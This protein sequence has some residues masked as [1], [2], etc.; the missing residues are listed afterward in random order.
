MLLI[1]T[2]NRVAGMPGVLT[3]TLLC[4]F[5]LL[6]CTDHPAD[7]ATYYLSPTGSDT[8]GDGSSV[9]PWKTLY[10]A[11]QAVP[12]R[13]GHII[14]LKEGIYLLDKTVNSFGTRAAVWINPGI[15]LEGE[16][17][18]TDRDKTVILTHQDSSFP[19]NGINISTGNFETSPGGM[20]NLTIDGD[21]FAGY[22]GVNTQKISNFTVDNVSFKNLSGSALG[23]NVTG[24]GSHVVGQDIS[25]NEVKNSY[26]SK[27]KGYCVGGDGWMNSSIHDCYMDNSDIANPSLSNPSPWGDCVNVFFVGSTRIYNN[28]MYAPSYTSPFT[29]WQQQQTQDTIC[30]FYSS[31]GNEIDHNELGQWVTLVGSTTLNGYDRII[32]VHDN[33][34]FFPYDVAGS[35]IELMCSDSDV[36]NN[37]IDNCEIG[38]LTDP[39]AV[40]AGNTADD[41][42]NVRVFNNVFRRTFSGALYESY[43]IAFRNSTNTTA[44]NW[45]I[46]NNVFDGFDRGF[47]MDGGGFVANLNV[48]NNVFLNTGRIINWGYPTVLITSANFTNNIWHY[49][50]DF[51]IN[52]APPAETNVVFANNLPGEATSLAA[53]S[54]AG[55]NLS[56]TLPTAFYAP[57][58]ETALPVN[59]GTANI[60]PGITLSGFSGSAPDIGVYEWTGDGDGNTAQTIAAA[61]A[62]PNPVTTGTTTALTAL[63]TNNGS[64][65]S[66]ARTFGDADR[67]SFSPDGVNG[68]KR[69]RGKE[70]HDSLYQSGNSRAS[71]YIEIQ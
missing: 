12:G 23:M 31:G 26:F 5:A 52:P 40:S 48:K 70:C 1:S 49:T 68:A 18:S 50:Q 67:A 9:N 19:G 45:S 56:G 2:K 38:I 51:D 15:T 63:G 53:A 71:D 29:S 35:A 57:S 44:R 22:G 64:A 61:S 24:N 47:Q 11:G 33:H 20:R 60:A 43:G 27:T 28:T 41:V 7:A 36:Y 66:L 34:V 25:G 37:Y 46:Y 8:S 30:L 21:D 13:Q 3:L 55:L 69:E 17:T 42:T 6:V 39:G 62:S 58:S 10:K 32:K 59:A 14:H 16:N 65:A 4:L 54:A